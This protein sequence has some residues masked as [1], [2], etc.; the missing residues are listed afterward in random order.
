[1]SD[2]TDMLC[3][4]IQKAGAKIAFWACPH[5]CRSHVDWNHEGL[6]A[7]ATCR[8]CG[9]TSRNPPTVL[10]QIR[11]LTTEVREK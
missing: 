5:G 3:D 11:E 10:E 4:L 6:T 1:M 9:E 7:T 2:D 8:D